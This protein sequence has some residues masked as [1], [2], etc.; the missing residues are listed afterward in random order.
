M[1]MWVCGKFFMTRQTI[2]LSLNEGAVCK[3]NC[4]LPKLWKQST[5]TPAQPCSHPLFYIV[6]GNRQLLQGS[7]ICL[8]LRVYNP[9]IPH[10]G[11]FFSKLTDLPVYFTQFFSFFLCLSCACS[12]IGFVII[13]RTV[14]LAFLQAGK[15]TLSHCSHWIIKKN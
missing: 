15:L 8:R 2:V 5:H 11:L 10:S 1:F 7:Q 12:L 3:T 14:P 4:H 6:S 9:V 13:T